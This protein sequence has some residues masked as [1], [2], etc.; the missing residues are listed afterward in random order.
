MTRTGPQKYPE[1]S[2]AYWH[3]DN[4]A[5][6]E[7]ESNVGVVH[8]TE[9]KSVPSYG[10]GASAPNLT[11]KPDM[12]RKRLQWYQHF[13]FDISA[14]ALMNR[15]GGVETNTLNAVQV[16]LVGTC[17]PDHRVSWGS[18]RAGVDYIYW[19]DAPDWALA[20]LGKFVRWCYD[21]HGIR[22]ES[23]V[24]WK[25]YPSS[26]GSNG[27][28]LSG[29]QWL[30]YY[31]WLGHQHV[32]ENS[33][34][35]PGDLNFKRVLEHARGVARATEEDDMPEFIHV[36]ETDWETLNPGEWNATEFHTEWADEPDGHYDPSGSQ[37]VKGP[38]VFD[39]VYWIR[40]KDF[41]VGEQ[42]QVRMARVKDGEITQKHSIAE[43][44]GTTGDAFAAVPIQHKLEKGEGMRVLVYHWQ[45][46]PIQYKAYLTALRWSR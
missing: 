11:A 14:R 16:E 12:V 40:L 5:G 26:Y 22:M 6:D 20:E 33:H 21:K 35:D 8:T 4:F 2:L 39:G 36:G 32:P 44:H 17:D 42:V 29:D 23:S 9:G 15:Y 46:E 41:P 27:V 37:F 13:D 45:P 18:D 34:G 31:G 43:V 1:A 3:Q 19:P 30:G 10:G 25:S 24:T 38:C 7:M 28:R